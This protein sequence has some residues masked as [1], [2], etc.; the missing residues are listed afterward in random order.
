MAFQQSISPLLTD[1][2]RGAQSTESPKERVHG[3]RE[4]ENEK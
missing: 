3:H 1:I 4:Y 2:Q